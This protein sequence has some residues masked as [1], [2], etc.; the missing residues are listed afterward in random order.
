[1]GRALEPG[2]ER[3]RGATGWR[4][5]AWGFLWGA[6]R[7]PG[8]RES[9][10]APP[11]LGQ[12][13]LRDPGLS[14]QVPAHPL[15]PPGEL[16]VGSSALDSATWRV[17]VSHA[18]ICSDTCPFPTRLALYLP[19]SATAQKHLWSV[20]HIERT[21]PRRLAPR[22]TKAR[23][24]IVTKSEKPSVASAWGEGLQVQ[25]ALGSVSHPRPHTC[26]RAHTPPTS[27]RRRRPQEGPRQAC[28]AQGPGAETR[29]WSECGLGRRDW[30][31]GHPHGPWGGGP[32]SWDPGRA[33][34]PGL[35]WGRWD[36][37]R[38]RQPVSLLPPQRPARRR[39]SGPRS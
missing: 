10:G 13:S 23:R 33:P 21:L 37:S 8:D 12:R 31:A 18:V 22:R 6:R 20:F 25:P 38:P 27:P 28:T 30:T 26:G 35:R 7:V 14:A 19:P 36:G 11:V 34:E 9:T 24:W 17:P 4:P 2:E 16:C 29:M 32:W 3:P 5:C 1:M 15:L 39:L